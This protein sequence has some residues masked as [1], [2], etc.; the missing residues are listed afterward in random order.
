MFSKATESTVKIGNTH[1]HY[2]T[3]GKGTHPLVIL[4]G[5][6]DGYWP[7]HNNARSLASQYKLFAKHFK[8]YVFSRKNMLPPVFTTRDMAK[9][10]SE[11]M[12]ILGLQGAYVMGIS[13]GGMIAQHLA[14]DYPEKVKKLVLVVTI[15]RQNETIQKVISS[16]MDFA[17]NEDFKGFMYDSVQK[18]YS[19]AMY[20]KYKPILPLIVLSR[21]PK[22][23]TYDRFLIQADACLTHHSFNGLSKITCPVLVAGGDDDRVVGNNMSEE[24]AENIKDSELIIYKG[25]GHGVYEEVDGFYDRVVGYLNR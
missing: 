2:V 20:K 10:Q 23:I 12:D 1:M 14:I 9:D 3:F 22:H 18:V 4:P 16:W 11:A 25:I 21:K 13:Q 19:P 7:V 8:V 5:L 17:R 15:S 24:I 6:G